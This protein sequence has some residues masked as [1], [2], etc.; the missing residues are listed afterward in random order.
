MKFRTLLRND[1]LQTEL[2]KKGAIVSDFLISNNIT[3]LLEHYTESATSPFDAE[4]IITL[5]EK[6]NQKLQSKVEYRCINCTPFNIRFKQ[7]AQFQNFTILDSITNETKSCSLHLLAPLLYE[8]DQFLVFKFLSGAHREYIPFRGKNTPDYYANIREKLIPAFS[9]LRIKPGQA[10]IFFSNVPFYIQS[11]DIPLLE[12]SILPY[13][14]RPTIYEFES[15]VDGTF[16][17]PYETHLKPYIEYLAGA[18]NAIENMKQ[19][20]KK[21]YTFTPQRHKENRVLISNNSKN[22]LTS[23][24]SAISNFFRQ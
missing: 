22:K 13:E 2:L 19:L 14:A 24:I 16:L 12:I 1:S 23:T 11:R 21:P 8:K 9:S 20:R 6:L 15:N 3:W 4:K 5:H 18:K 7:S 10:A 17:Q